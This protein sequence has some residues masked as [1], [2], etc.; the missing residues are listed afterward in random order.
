MQNSRNS[1][2]AKKNIEILEII[3]Y[4]NDMFYQKY[5]FSEIRFLKKNPN[6][7]PISEKTYFWENIYFTNSKNYRNST[8][9]VIEFSNSI[10]EILGILFLKF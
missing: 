6:S 9:F 10:L 7:A 2:N 3:F 4:G 1:R 5:V 8:S